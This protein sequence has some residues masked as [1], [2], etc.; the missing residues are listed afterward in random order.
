M[1][2]K[3]QLDVDVSDKSE[4]NDVQ[5]QNVSFFPELFVRNKIVEVP[6]KIKLE[7]PELVK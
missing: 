4:L 5:E 6:S 7:S 1:S 3:N 2:D